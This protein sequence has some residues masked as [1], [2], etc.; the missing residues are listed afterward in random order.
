MISRILTTIGRNIVAWLALFVALTGTS[1]AASHYIITST[2]QI[3]PSVLT[4]LRAGR[5]A[6]PNTATPGPQGPPGKEGAPAGPGP[7]GETGPR[8]EAGQRGETGPKGEIGPRGEAGAALA[9]AHVL[10]DGQLDAS[11]SK[12][13]AGVNV[14][15]PEPGVLHLGSELPAA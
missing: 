6:S 14:E 9:Y 13:V 5:G 3:K 2:G 11:G 4:Q 12:N 8:G 7:R 15:R 1:L 10:K